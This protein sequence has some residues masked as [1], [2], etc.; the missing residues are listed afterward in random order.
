MRASSSGH[1]QKEPQR[2][3]SRFHQQGTSSLVKGYLNSFY[4]FLR[5]AVYISESVLRF[6]EPR[7]N[8]GIW[9]WVF[10]IFWVSRVIVMYD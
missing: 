7:L 9:E 4:T 8:I 5:M 2:T 3:A 1:F 6:L 10:E